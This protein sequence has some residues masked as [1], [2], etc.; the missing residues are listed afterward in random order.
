MANSVNPSGFPDARI[1]E[2][3]YGQGIV[4]VQS[5]IQ[6]QIPLDNS[7][8]KVAFMTPSNGY[9]KYDS[10]SRFF[11]TPSMKFTSAVIGGSVEINPRPQFTRYA[12][13]RS[14]GIMPGRNDVTPTN[15][16]GNYGMGRYYS[17]AF[18]DNAQ[19]IYMRFGVPQYN[20]I[21]SF[22]LNAADYGQTQLARTGRIPF[23][24]RATKAIGTDRKS[25]V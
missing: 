1:V 17:E 19:R 8:V 16:S 2:N 6:T 25:V 20:S 23:L 12:D 11:T 3:A 14:K 4:P 5:Q 21:I 9:T 7:W 10:V 13:I 24:Y 22:L 18:D 15:V